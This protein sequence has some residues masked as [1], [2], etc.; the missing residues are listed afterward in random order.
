MLKKVR[1]RNYKSILDVVLDLTFAEGKAPNGWRDYEMMP[2]LEGD[3]HMENRRVPV[4][5]IYGA[6]ASGKTNVLEAV[7]CFKEVL[8]HGIGNHFRSNRI[9]AK[10]S[11]TTFS[12]EMA[13]GEGTLEYGIEY[14][15]FTIHHEW[16]ISTVGEARDTVFEISDCAVKASGLAV[17][18]YTE[19]RL[20]QIFKVE[21]TNGHERQQKTFLNCLI[22]GYPGLSGAVLS[23]YSTF[24]EKT[25]VYLHN[26]QSLSYAL[27]KL[28]D[29]RSTIST[30]DAFEKI[31]RILQ[32]FDFSLR[33]MT[34][35]R[36]EVAEDSLFR[37]TPG[38]SPWYNK[39]L[40]RDD[41]GRLVAEQIT[42]FHRRVD[43]ELEP[44]DF[45]TEESEGTRVAAGLVGICLW[46]LET[47]SVVFFDELDRSLHPLILVELVRLFKRKNT[48]QHNGQLV[49]TLHDTTLLEDPT[50]RVSE[51]AVINNNPHTGTTL[52]RLSELD[53]GEGDPVRNIH[54]FRKQYMEGVL[55]GVPHPVA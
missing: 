51:V 13:Y 31:I 34:L 38:E 11:T 35:E 36:T 22:R 19:E 45:M 25:A 10:Y 15:R 7:L 24:V 52:T 4:L 41:K 43:G 50:V 3:G 9:N 27:R 29:S 1:I 14:D 28:T 21:C 6:N 37:H 23:V 2:F 26:G 44:F 53:R 33:K 30:E 49:F 55:T 40:S 12:L 20:A 47:G 5:S 39:M 32:K 17:E 54:N 8:K 46:A 48:N 18:S 16:L 42:A